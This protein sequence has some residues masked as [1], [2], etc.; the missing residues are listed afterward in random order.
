MSRI[1]A[2]IGIC[3]GFAAL[4][5]CVIVPHPV[6]AD[7][8]HHGQIRVQDG[9]IVSAGPR[10]LLEKVSKRIVTGHGDIRLVDAIAFRDAAFP[11][12]GWQL[13]TILDPNGGD[14]VAATGT[15]YLVLIGPGSLTSYGD[16]KGGYVPAL[17]GVQYAEQTSR[18]VALVIELASR[19]PVGMYSVEADGTPVMV[20]WIVLSAF[21][22]P[23]TET[24]VL[25]G[26]AD[27]IVAQLRGRSLHSPIRVAVLAAEGHSNPF[28]LPLANDPAVADGS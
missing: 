8:E 5:G 15:D 20:T 1:V 12:G 24:A 18:L 6:P 14:A 23:M 16:D 25:D 13:A 27:T 3:T 17:A 11:E 2:L 26:L 19:E 21:K 10:R 28:N 9:V 7:I 22:H 4:S